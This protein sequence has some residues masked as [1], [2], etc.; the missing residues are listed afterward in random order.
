MRIWCSLV[1]WTVLEIFWHV[2]K[3]NEPLM[4]PKR[5]KLYSSAALGTRDVCD[6]NFGN[7]VLV[8]ELCVQAATR[9]KNEAT[10][11]LLQ[12]EKF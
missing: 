4:E 12:T 5:I 8:Y 3:D 6:P 7:R 11:L 1:G 9:I 10:H 2:T